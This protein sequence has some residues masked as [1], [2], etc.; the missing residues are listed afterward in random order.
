MATFKC[1]LVFGTYTLWWE[2]HLVH[3]GVWR[4]CSTFWS[5][6][7]W[8]GSWF[9]LLPLSNHVHFQ[10]SFLTSIFI[11]SLSASTCSSPSFISFLDIVVWQHCKIWV[12]QSHCLCCLGIWSCI[13]G[14][15]FPWI[16]LFQRGSCEGGFWGL[17]LEAWLFVLFVDSKEVCLK[18]FVEAIVLQI[19]TLLRVV[20]PCDR[21]DVVKIGLYFIS[22]RIK[23]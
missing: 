19:D 17:N 13:L 20:S 3:C 4:T 2:D 1:L 21:Q 18:V 5:S 10:H 6:W 16:Y 9:G 23:H 7:V 15:V 11:E 8:W 12:P 22:Y 14:F